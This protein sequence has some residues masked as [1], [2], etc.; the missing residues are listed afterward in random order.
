MSLRR[1]CPFNCA[2]EVDALRR[3]AHNRRNARTTQKDLATM[4]Q[5]SH[6]FDAVIAD[7][8]AANAADPRTV[9]TGGD[10][11]PL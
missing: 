9:T 7:I 3:S 6:R 4:P 1:A 2:A 11:A 5:L 8:D 10:V